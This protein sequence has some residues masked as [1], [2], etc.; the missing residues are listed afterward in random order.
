MDEL[1]TKI[2]SKSISDLKQNGTRTATK[3]IMN[4]C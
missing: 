1:D 3:T 2:E 4:R